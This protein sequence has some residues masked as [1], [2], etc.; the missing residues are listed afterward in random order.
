MSKVNLVELIHPEMDILFLGLNAP[1]ESNNNGHW[2]SGSLA[3][4]NLLFKSGLITERITT[5]MKANLIVFGSNS[6]NYKNQIFGIT[7]L[8]NELVE[9]V[10]NKVTTTP[11]HVNRI[12][13]ILD[14]NKVD[15]LCIMHSKV[16]ERFEQSGLVK[17]KSGELD[18]YGEIGRYKSTTIYEVPFPTAF[19]AEKEKYYK[20]LIS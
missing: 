2:Y 8:N 6:I 16:G 3:F 17:R 15:K 11:E 7:D 5:P 1:T 12:L 18:G 13:N 20:L 14:N 10:S 19:I 4:W 9:T